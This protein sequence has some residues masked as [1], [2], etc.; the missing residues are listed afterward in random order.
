MTTSAATRSGFIAAILAGHGI[1]LFLLLEHSGAARRQAP[2][3]ESGKPIYMVPISVPVDRA[4]SALRKPVTDTPTAGPTSPIP[5]S[6][7]PGP[8]ELHV[9]GGDRSIDWNRETVSAAQEAVEPRTQT[10][11][12]HRAGD[13]ET[14][15]PGRERRW[16][17]EKCFWEFGNPPPLF[18]EPGPRIQAIHCVSGSTEPNGHLLDEIKPRYLQKTD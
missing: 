4:A 1:L 15:G 7:L 18:A 16:V 11:R 2:A 12:G 14:L 10:S 3:A 8:D 9:R 17:S 5:E 13:I 6:V